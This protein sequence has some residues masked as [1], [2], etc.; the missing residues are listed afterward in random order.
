MSFQLTIKNTVDEKCA[1]CRKNSTPDRPVLD[2][3][4]TGRSYSER[5]FIVIHKDCL[6][7]AIAKEE[8]ILLANNPSEQAELREKA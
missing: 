3:W 1:R 6:L 4:T 5:N 2:M 8:A 7:K